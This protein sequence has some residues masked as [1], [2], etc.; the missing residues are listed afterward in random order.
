MHHVAVTVGK[1]LDLDVPR[2]LHIFFD[3]H[4]RVA[5]RRLR[6]ALRPFQGLHKVSRLID[7]AHPLAT[8]ARHRFDQDRKAHLLR[9]ARQHRRR[10]IFAQVARHHRHPSLDHQNL[11]RVFEPHSANGARGRSDENQS[12]LRARLGKIRIFRQETIARMHGLRAAHPRRVQDR[13][14][15]Q[16]TFPHRCRPNPHGLIRHRNMWRARIGVRVDGNGAKS[17]ALG[18]THHTASDLAAIG[19]QKR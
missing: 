16:I 6:L 11:R 19:N 8:A 2:R 15:V 18:R 12:S 10:L 13:L 9:L 14:D 7:A 17:H 3:Q 1:N 4:P 5:E